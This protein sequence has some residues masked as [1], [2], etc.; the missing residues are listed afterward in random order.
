MVSKVKIKF[1]ETCVE[2]W[3]VFLICPALFTYIF[4]ND[5]NIISLNS[6]VY[7]KICLQEFNETVCNN[8]RNFSSNFS[9]LVQTESTQK[10]I[11][12]NMAFLLP[13]ILS[14]IQLASIGDRTLNYKVPL[15][16]SVVGSI[17]QAVI[18]YVAVEQSIELC[19]VLLFVGQVVNGACGGGSLAFISSCFSHIAVVSNLKTASNAKKDSSIRFSLCESSL[20]L[21]QFFGAFSS[22]YIIGNKTNLNNFQHAYIISFSLYVAVLVYVILMFE[23]LKRKEKNEKNAQLSLMGIQQQIEASSSISASNSLDVSMSSKTN[24][25]ENEETRQQSKDSSNIVLKYLKKQ[26]YFLIEVWRL[27]SKKREN[28]ARFHILSLLAL[29]FFGASISLGIVSLQYLYLIKKPISLTQVDYGLFKAL[30]TLFRAIS[31]LLVLPLLKNYFKVSDRL[32]Y[33]MGLVSELLNLVFFA[34]SSWYRYLIW[35]GIYKITF[36]FEL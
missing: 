23:Y 8:I 2:Y 30:N 15:V 34:A 25:I 18:C 12:L 6:L 17:G 33:V 1:N 11:Y 22:G 35:I 19:F 27:L 5:I 29:Y 32:L 31:L 24:L 16:V 26:L 10:M 21:G 3:R 20:L 28:N 14:I 7:R 4:S 9:T 36:L 13:A